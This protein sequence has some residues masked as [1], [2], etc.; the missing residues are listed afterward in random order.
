MTDAQ[1]VGDEAAESNV[2]PQITQIYK[3]QRNLRINSDRDTLAP[4]T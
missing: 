1:Y 2:H 3:N 4:V